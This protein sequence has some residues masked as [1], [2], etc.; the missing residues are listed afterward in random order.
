[1]AVWIFEKLTRSRSWPFDGMDSTSLVIWVKR[2]PSPRRFGH[3]RSAG[4]AVQELRGLRPP[5]RGAPAG[6]PI[7][8]T[9]GRAGVGWN[10]RRRRRL[11][12][13]DLGAGL[14]ELLLDL[15]GFR[16]GHAFLHRL[17]RAV[18]QVL[19]L[20]EAQACD[21]PHDLDDVDLL[22]AALGQDHIEG[23]LD[24]RGG[25]SGGG[26]RHAPRHHHRHGGGRRNTEFALQLFH[27]LG[28]LEHRCRL[29]IILDVVLRDRG[30]SVLLNQ[31][32]SS[33]ESIRFV[34]YRS[35][36]PRRASPQG[37]GAAPG[38]GAVP[39]VSFFRAISSRTR[40]RPR[41]GAFIT[42]TRRTIGALSTDSSRDTR[43]SR[44][45]SEATALI[46]CEPMTRPATSPALTSRP[47]L[48]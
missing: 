36:P 1:M 22:V 4:G 24:L 42:V 17:R 8:G 34:R 25:R 47:R 21:L 20:L 16:L 14:R 33:R 23:V 15:L 28:H 39:C 38:A 44:D 41:A 7:G 37:A 19:R 10:A 26:A 46:A 43:T 40:T 6:A 31:Y 27:Q 29:E 45:G 48:S 2:P 9:N 30:H 35:P 11:L 3:G 5:G 12:Q 18:H 32:A 13:L